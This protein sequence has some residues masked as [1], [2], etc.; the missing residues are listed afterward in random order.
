[1]KGVEVGAGVGAGAGS[2]PKISKIS[3]L[4]G[5]LTDWVAVVV[6]AVTVGLTYS[7]TS[8]FLSPGLDNLLATFSKGFLVSTT[9]S[10]FFSSFLLSFVVLLSV[11]EASL[12]LSRVDLL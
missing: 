2:L 9:I 11:L 10:G 3:L 4:L 6:G 8:T 5:L 12:Y 7:K 1:V